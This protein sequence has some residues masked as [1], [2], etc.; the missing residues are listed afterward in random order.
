MMKT[1]GRENGR[2]RALRPL[3]SESGVALVLTL[4]L[5]LLVTV[6]MT[7]YFVRA[8]SDSRATASYG[9]NVRSELLAEGAADS[10]VS[11]VIEEIVANSD[12]KESG[13]FIWY[14][15]KKVDGKFPSMVLSRSLGGE[16]PATAAFRNL[17]K[18]SNAEK[19]FR[20]GLPS[21]AS[22]LRTT[23]RSRDGRWISASRWNLPALLG[24]E[25]KLETFA[26]NMVPNWIYVEEDGK[27][28]KTDSPK[29][30]GRYAYNVYDVGGL[31]NINVAGNNGSKNEQVGPKGALA[32]LDLKAIPGFKEKPEGLDAILKWRTPYVNWSVLGDSSSSTIPSG[33][34]DLLDYIKV[35]SLSGWQRNASTNPS[36]KGNAFLSR[37]DLIRFFEKNSI[38]KK[39]LPF[40]THFNLDLNAPSF[41]PDT[42]ILKVL[43]HSML[44]LRESGQTGN[45]VFSIQDKINPRRSADIAQVKNELGESFSAPIL[46][47]RFPLSYLAYVKT[48]PGSRPRG[49]TDEM[50]KKYFGLIRKDNFTW[51]YEDAE[52]SRNH[53][54]TL[55]EVAQERQKSGAKREPNFF[56]ILKSVIQVG[57][58]GQHKQATPAGVADNQIEP[59][60]NV[61]DDH[62]VRIGAAIIDQADE[63]SLPTRILFNYFSGSGTSYG[64]I[65]GV[66]DLPYLYAIR[67]VAYRK[68][69]PEP[70]NRSYIIQP[71]L[72]DPHNPFRNNSSNGKVPGT[73]RV[74]A[75]SIGM[76]A[77]GGRGWSSIPPK[78][79][80]NKW[81]QFNWTSEPP[82]LS[83]PNFYEPQTILSRDYPSKARP[84]VMSDNSDE[85]PLFNDAM[86]GEIASYTRSGGVNPF[87]NGT[88]I[89]FVIGDTNITIPD[90]EPKGD[91]PVPPPLSDS[92]TFTGGPL[93]FLLQ[94]E[95]DGNFYTYDRLWFPPSIASAIENPGTINAP[96]TSM[97]VAMFVG[98][99]YQFPRGM[100][101]KE[102]TVDTRV[103]AAYVKTDPRSQR[104]MWGVNRARFAATDAGGVWRDTI[105][106][107][108][109]LSHL[110]G[111][112]GRV[113]AGPMGYLDTALWT[114]GPRAD[115]MTGN[116][117]RPE[118]FRT[119]VGFLSLN[120][121][122]AEN[123]GA[124]GMV[125]KDPDG[126]VRRA[127]VN[128][129]T[130]NF[131]DTRDVVFISPPGSSTR[132]IGFPSQKFT[133]RLK[134]DVY[135][136]RPIVLNRPFRS[137]GE[138]ANAFRDVPWKNLDLSLPESPDAGL[139]DVFCVNEESS[140]PNEIYPLT[141]SRINLNL[142]SLPV[143]KAML[144]GA[145]TQVGVGE[146]PLRY[147]YLSP[148]QTDALAARIDDYR[149]VDGS[150]APAAN[151]AK[152]NG[153]DAPSVNGPL[154][155][156]AE[157][158]GRVSGGKEGTSA[159]FTGLQPETVINGSADDK[160][161]SERLGSAARAVADVS[162][163]RTWNLM[164]D[165]VAQSGTTKG[166][167]SNFNVQAETRFWM[168]VSID[169]FT[170]KVL[171]RSIER[172]VE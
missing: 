116:T 23:E 40:L 121:K 170:G 122:L 66:E 130:K 123:S 29:I 109:S 75:N 2:G 78:S 108:A 99:K 150:R 153:F 9:S 94:Y 28:T 104:F 13:D 18:Q 149:R 60:A 52:G 114:L 7:A 107:A 126:V 119:D 48:D 131:F 151:A 115:G 39:T 54:K 142:C 32:F 67:L 12:G 36:E 84:I 167:L 26:D 92:C 102:E 41:S 156:L 138:L 154:R 27:T 58:L 144:T 171:A 110:D 44:D 72:W 145:A 43:R 96:F 51:Q 56:E 165:L 37:Q 85:R 81:I 160:I 134:D 19:G 21:E 86:K 132:N 118:V 46:F 91:P 53:I 55:A 30:V 90:V 111:V 146:S 139:L 80:N 163:V 169:R 17:V 34:L 16:I 63:D 31:V 33:K 71:T 50:T 11:K 22:D 35:G 70:N 106:E 3:K 100:M 147:Q 159:I 38:D 172:V 68:N 15:P 47:K 69:A 61:I 8:T 95:I 152:A 105:P 136:N 10:I 97:F 98:G 103:D 113:F 168:F 155:S 129:A 57:S 87:P 4:I 141:A 14:E 24:D 79:F 135:F 76:L 137:V 125:Y 82:S 64:E 42:E 25:T 45:R 5:L 62:I 143:L 74:V 65:Y 164:I 1:H 124:R 89:G 158:V 112:V 83:D 6:I 128:T 73:F 161:L 157:L 77:L 120:R 59:F 140:E 117:S 162:T 133:E 148:A 127:M 49:V 101:N 166:D 88:T 93:E 20:D